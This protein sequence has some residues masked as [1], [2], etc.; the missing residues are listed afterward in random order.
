MSTY[1]V[2]SGSYLKLRNAELGYSLPESITKKLSMQRARIALRADNIATIKKAGAAM[3][4]PGSIRKL[5]V[6]AIRCRSQ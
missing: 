2:E 4:I 5:R 6:T 1:Y 3:P